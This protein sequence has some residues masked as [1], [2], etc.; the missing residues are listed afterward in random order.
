MI[1][2]RDNQKIKWVRALQADPKT[3]HEDQAF[4][5]EGVRLVDEAL[6]SGWD[7]R[8]VIYTEGVGARGRDLMQKF[9]SGGVP[10]EQVTPS[11]MESAS[12]TRNPQ[13]I[14]A[15]LAAHTLPLPAPPNFIFIPDGVRDPGNLGTMLRSAA[16][17]GVQ[18]VLLP[19]GCV[20][21]FSPKVLRSAMGAHFR[22]P[23][24]SL[25]WDAIQRIIT[26]AGLAV[27]LAEADRGENYTQA[28]W[29]IPLALIVGSEAEGAGPAAQNLATRRV[30]IPMPGGSES[31]N[32]ASAAAIL[33]FEAVRQRTS[34]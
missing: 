20:D 8:W 32:A 34:V 24:H 23:I 33:L 5:V 4:V 16:A 15:V 25:P 19:P 18:G 28:N 13:G 31:L 2:S 11:V 26:Q 10:L 3:R 7:I 14:L 29:Q 6:A 27:L 12:D 30:F 21:P 1:T 17:A 9:E 22:L